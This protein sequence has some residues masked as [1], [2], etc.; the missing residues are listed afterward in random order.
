MWESPSIREHVR[1]EMDFRLGKLM[2]TLTFD[3]GKTSVGEYDYVYAG[4]YE[5]ITSSDFSADKLINNIHELRYIAEEYDFSA[6][7]T[8]KSPTISFIRYN[9]SFFY[10]MILLLNNIPSNASFVEGKAAKVNVLDR[11][12][13]YNFISK[14]TMN[15]S[16][17]VRKITTIEDMEMIKQALAEQY[18]DSASA[19]DE[20]LNIKIPNT[21]FDNIQESPEYQKLIDEYG[22]KIVSLYVTNLD[23]YRRRTY[24][25]SENV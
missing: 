22:E 19:V 1:E 11:D 23:K 24:E 20:W 12:Q 9:V 17:T 13:L 25:E 10:Q 8:Y 18:T 14:A 7:I 6:N 3:A 21:S 5:K 16:R 4:L 15:I 2:N